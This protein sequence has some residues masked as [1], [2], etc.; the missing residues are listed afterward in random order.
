MK[1]LFLTLLLSLNACQNKYPN[2]DDGLYAEI[3]TNK[4]TMVA[5]LYYD[6]VPVTVANF[7][8]LA[9]G[10]HPKLDDSLKGKPFYDGI[11][12]H[13]VM[14]KFMIQGGD[15]TGTGT[16]SAGFK[17]TSEFDPEL[18]HDRP[19]ILSM[20]NSGGISTNGSQFFITEVPYTRGDAF[21][22]NG[23]VKPCE[24]R[25]VSCHG[26][27][28]ELVLGLEV[29]DSISNVK[30]APR[31]NKPIEDVVIEKV[32][33]IRKGSAAKAF[34]AVSVFNEQEP[35]LIER[36]ETLREEQ[37]KVAAANRAKELEI[38]KE[39][40]KVSAEAFKTANAGK[41]EV[42]E[43]QTGMIMITTKKGTGVTPKP[44]DKVNINCAGF[45][46][47][48]TLFYTTWKEVAKANGIYNEQADKQGAYKPFADVYNSSARLVPGF[49]EAFL[50][51]NIGEKAKVFIPSYLGYGS[52]PNGPIPASSNLIFDVELV[53]IK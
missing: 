30:V 24:Q 46:E 9:E 11:I 33:I 20:A 16:G 40:S 44:T 18:K 5:K 8:G 23:N 51:M 21:D 38:L 47:D 26:V 49:R 25:G 36:F 10:N 7:V 1:F 41:G 4:G 45:L 15:P 6:K 3:T 19:G 27:F 13:R 48:G 50:R 53:N 52:K 2:L 31:S 32:T 17:F 35:L 42:F 22:N 37:E 28:G 34:D 14:D 39:Q 29:Q 43:S 12:F